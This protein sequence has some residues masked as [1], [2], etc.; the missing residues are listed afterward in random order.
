MYE[1]TAANWVKEMRKGNRMKEN[2]ENWLFSATVN[3]LMKFVISHFDKECPVD[4]NLI[5]NSLRCFLGQPISLCPT[6]QRISANVA[7]P[8]YE[9]GSR[10]MHS[11]KEFMRSQFLNEKYGEAWLRGFA[12]IMK[13]VEKFGARLPFIP[14]G[15]YRNCLEL[16]VPV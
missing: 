10:L 7:T 6:C 13:G 15:T 14:G 4:G 5:L 16:H 1:E 9:I 11:N 3:P 2:I 8:I 12:L